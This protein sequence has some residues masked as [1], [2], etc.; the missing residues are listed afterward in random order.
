MS[1]PSKI[2][3]KPCLQ[4]EGGVQELKASEVEFLAIPHLTDIV[5]ARTTRV[6]EV[7]RTAGRTRL[8]RA[9]K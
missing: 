4:F 2:Y 3:G 6:A 7:A 5:A 9:A 1:N 8:A